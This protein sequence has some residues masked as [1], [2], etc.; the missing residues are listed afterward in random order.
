MRDR[1]SWTLEDRRRAVRSAGGSF[2]SVK[3]GSHGSE[4]K[5]SGMRL[6]VDERS[7]LV[8]GDD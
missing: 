6:R 1:L 8:E 5:Y 3:D 7:E 4:M 2:L